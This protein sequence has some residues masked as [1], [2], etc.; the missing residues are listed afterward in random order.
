MIDLA[1]ATGIRGLKLTDL[2]RR[3]DFTAGP[4]TISPARRIVHGPAGEAHLEP[5]IMHVFLLLLDAQGEVVTRTELFDQCWGGVMV[6]DASLNRLIA[7][8][9]KIAARTGPGLFAVETIPRTGYRLTG[10]ILDDAPALATSEPTM[11]RRG[12]VGASLAVAA[13]AVGSTAL[14]RARWPGSNPRFDALMERGRTALRLDQAGADHAFRQAAAIEPGNATAWGLLAYALSSTAGNGPAELTGPAANAAEQAARRALAINAA[15]PNALL[16]LANAQSSMLDWLAREIEYRRILAIDPDNTLAMRALG[17]LLHGVGRCRD[18][19][20]VA[21]RAIAIEPL[22]ADHQARKAMR[23]WVLGRT[24]DA[25]RVID[26]ALDLWPT[27]RIV[28]LFRLMIYAYTGR[29]HAALALVDDERTQPILLDPTAAA[30]W[31]QSLE[32]LDQPTPATVERARAALMKGAQ[33]RTAAASWAIVTL[34]ALGQ[35]DDAFAVAD[36]FLLGRGPIIVRSRQQGSGLPLNSA[37]WRNTYGLFIPPTRALR[38]DPRFTPL[39]DGLGL[40]D[41]WNRR[42]IKPDAFLFAGKP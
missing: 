26:R 23:L 16:A 31:R 29:A 40:T 38:L 22:A 19:L 32:A 1:L 13:A 2:A 34:S 28:R 5:L 39:A 12:A 15:E 21:N 36:G 8:V 18:A 10:A 3:P 35:L 37:G 6:G 17:Q 4:F 25:D 42:A 33:S 41:Y 27:H 7:R 24:A 20:A 30:I 11:S 9:R 14:W